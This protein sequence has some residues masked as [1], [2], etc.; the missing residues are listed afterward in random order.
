MTRTITGRDAVDYA[1]E[2]GLSHVHKYADPIEGHREV[3][4]AEAESILIEDPSLIYLSEVA[5][6]EPCPY[7]MARHVYCVWCGWPI[8]PEGV[9]DD[10][11]PPRAGARRERCSDTACVSP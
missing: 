6:D 11:A 2:S 5:A 9:W 10:T 8:S 3:T 1:R 7:T 4:L